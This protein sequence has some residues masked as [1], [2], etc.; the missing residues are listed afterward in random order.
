VG[1]LEVLDQLLIRRRL[2]E[3]GEILAVE[4]LDQ[5]LFDRCQIV[6]GPHH[7]R[8][9][10]EA[11]AA[12]RPPPPLAGDQLEAGPSTTADQDRLQHTDLLDRRGQ[13]GERLLVEVHAGLVGIRGDVGDR[14]LDE[15]GTLTA[16][17]A[18][19][20]LGRD[21]RAESLTET[22]TP[23]HGTSLATSRYATAPRER[24][25]NVMIG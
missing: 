11:G 25:S 22:A 6:G 4:V 13:L 2:L 12:G 21:E 1:E 20:P 9:R 3:R 17:G 23:N 14:D 19:P 5:R 8:D 18:G 24:G 15:E 10:R 7:R 16:L